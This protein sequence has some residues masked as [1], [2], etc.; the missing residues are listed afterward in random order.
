MSD[1]KISYFSLMFSM[2][3]NLVSCVSGWRRGL[4]VTQFAL[5]RVVTCTPMVGRMFAISSSSDDVG[6]VLDLEL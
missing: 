4:L 5:V 2:F 6:V 3:T 1:D